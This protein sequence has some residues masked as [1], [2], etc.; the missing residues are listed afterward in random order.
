MLDN[1]RNVFEK[2]NESAA[3]LCVLTEAVGLYLNALRFGF[4]FENR[5]FSYRNNYVPSW[6]VTPILSSW[7]NEAYSCGDDVLIDFQSE[8]LE[9]EEAKGFHKVFEF[10]DMC[11]I[12]LRE[13]SIF[14][15]FYTEFRSCFRKT[16]PLLYATGLQWGDFVAWWGLSQKSRQ[17]GILFV[18][19]LGL[20]LD[21]IMYDEYKL[22]TVMVRLMDLRRG[23]MEGLNHFASDDDLSLDCYKSVI[24]MAQAVMNSEV[25]LI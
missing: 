14:G 2:S 3:G 23:A 7:P 19:L 8:L 21:S 15:A 17:R 20:V 11:G 4:D 24:K 13:P 16:D 9:W 1:A 22:T 10:L 5:S 6:M 12:V 25:I 18:D